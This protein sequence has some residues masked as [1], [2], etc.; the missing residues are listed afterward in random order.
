M[1]SLVLESRAG[2]VVVQVENTALMTNN[3]EN[4]YIGV[5]L[6]TDDNAGMY[7]ALHNRRASEFA[8]CCGKRLEVSLL[9][10]NSRLS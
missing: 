2:L 6:Y 3:K 4:D 8:F 10:P 5:N 9:A 1:L 7:N